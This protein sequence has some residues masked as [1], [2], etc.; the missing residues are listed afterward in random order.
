MLKVHIE[1]FERMHSV[2]EDADFDDYL[3]LLNKQLGLP[4]VELSVSSKDGRGQHLRPARYRRRHPRHAVIRE[5]MPNS[6]R[7]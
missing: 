1:M 7:L 3:R 6:N 5:S 2:F 4:A